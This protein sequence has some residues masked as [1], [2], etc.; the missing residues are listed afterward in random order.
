V[1]QTPDQIRDDIAATRERM[2]ETIRAVALKADVGRQMTKLARSP[3]GHA[4]G[5]LDEALDRVA[6]DAAM[7]DLEAGAAEAVREGPAPL[8]PGRGEIAPRRNGTLLAA[9]ACAAAG[10]LV[11]LG[12]LSRK[13]RQASAAA[14]S[15]S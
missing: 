14:G 1:G 13:S 2:T 15:E 3:V 4:D 9:L 8:E 7:G 6:S 10:V 12:T 5:S 11:G